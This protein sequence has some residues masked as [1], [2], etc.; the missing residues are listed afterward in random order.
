M[1]TVKIFKSLCVVA[2]IGVSLVSCSADN[3]D[4]EASETQLELPADVLTATNEAALGGGIRQAVPRCPR[5]IALTRLPGPVA[6]RVRTIFLDANRT[7]T[8][9]TRVCR[10]NGQLFIVR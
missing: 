6:S 10:A 9:T 1:K 4:A 3:V 8:G 5:A 2:L 7:V